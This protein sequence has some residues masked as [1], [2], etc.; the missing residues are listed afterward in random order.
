MVGWTWGVRRDGLPRD[1]VFGVMIVVVLS[2][3]Y[4]SVKIYPMYAFNV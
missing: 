1:T 3:V 2:R 4:V